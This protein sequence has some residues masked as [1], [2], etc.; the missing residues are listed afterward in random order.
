MRYGALR[1]PRHFL[2]QVPQFALG[3]LAPSYILNFLRSDS[4]T[5]VGKK[6]GNP[7]RGRIC[8]AAVFQE[9]SDTGS[10][11]SGP[12]RVTRR[13]PILQGDTGNVNDIVWNR[14]R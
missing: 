14:L 10:I 7:Q 9:G 2:E 4:L 11:K 5:R 13:W 8:G 3:C 6:Y 1:V 12:G